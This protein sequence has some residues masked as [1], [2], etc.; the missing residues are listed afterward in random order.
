MTEVGWR[1]AEQV[2]VT[3]GLEEGERV[4]LRPLAVAVDGMVVEVLDGGAE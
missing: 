4:C 1:D 3:G 2:L